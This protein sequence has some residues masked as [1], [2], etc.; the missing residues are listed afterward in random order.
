MKELKKGAQPKKENT[1]T[2]KHSITLFAICIVNF[3]VSFALLVA[4]KHTG[5]MALYGLG[6]GIA[7]V[8]LEIS[9][10]MNKED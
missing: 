3:L 1:Q 6:A 8:T 4:G 10:W 7:F 5:S 2:H 9:L